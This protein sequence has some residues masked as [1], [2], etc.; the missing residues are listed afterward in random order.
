MEKHYLM[1]LTALAVGFITTPLVIKLAVKIGAVD[2]PRDNRRIHKK[3]MPLIG[4]LAIYLAFI[5]SVFIF[6][7]LNKETVGL[8]L[9]STFI[10]I[11]GM[12]DDIRP[13]K[14]KTKLV[15]QIIASLILVA[16]GITIKVVTNPFDKVYGMADLSWLSIPATLFW[17]V[18][19]T[20]AF[21][22]I[23]GLDGLAAGIASISCITLFIVSILN[24]REVA[25]MLTAILAGSTIGFI[26]YNFNPAK[27]FMGDTG[28]Q[29]LGFV[30]AA[31]SI[32]GA[33]K[34]A[35]AIIITVPILALGL[36]IYDTLS[37]MV[38]RFVNKKPVMEG[39]REH[40]H[41]K[42]I[43]LGLSQKQAVFVMYIIS[44]MLGLTAIFAAELNTL[45]SFLVLITVMLIV[46]AL[47]KQI[48]ILK[49]NKEEGNQ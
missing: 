25:A 24:G 49:R 36:P 45:Q 38:R 14:A 34:S 9:G 22:L 6:M 15:L 48:G 4:G 13:M 37:S 40:L 41:H 17:V 35:A 1:F 39:D 23:D 31:V 42:L 29:F 11:A 47:S 2:I 44:G 21:N 7:P 10:T 26:P 20:N 32:Q 28:A 12:I 16:S 27:I 18:G 5:V 43:D 30:L 8:V 33:I 46:I 3:P 19:I